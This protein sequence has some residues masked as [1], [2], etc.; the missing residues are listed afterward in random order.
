MTLDMSDAGKAT[1]NGGIVSN[2]AVDAGSNNITTT[3]VITGGSFNVGGTNVIDTSRN[4][5]NMGNVNGAAG[6]FGSLEVDD[7]TINGTEIDL[8]SGSL[9]LDVASAIKLDADGGEV[10][11]LDGGTEI[12]VVSMGNQNMNIESKQA[13]KDII[14]KGIDGSSDLTALTIDMSAAGQLLAVANTPTNPTYSFAGDNNTG[15]TRPTGDTVTIV[16]GGTE[17]VRVDSSGNM[18]VGAEPSGTVKGK[19][20]IDG[21]TG[22]GGIFDALAIKHI[23]TTTTGDGPALKFEGE[24]NSNDWALA[25]LQVSNGGAGYGANVEFKLHPGDS[26]QGSNVAN[27]FGLKRIVSNQLQMILHAGGASTYADEAS[28]TISGVANTSCL[29]SIQSQR[30][31][32]SNSIAYDAALFFCHYGIDS[33]SSVVELADPGGTFAGSDTDGMVC[34]YKGNNSAD[35]IVKNR[36]GYSTGLSIQVIPFLGN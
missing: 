11:F 10:Q 9:T 33:G 27:A 4:L 5:V 12:G 14:F 26:V 18:S 7:I 19:I 16:T 25:K 22:S 23:N 13:D 6:I 28:Y 21:G 8:S 35:V 29:I 31:A 1:F 15:I 36:L 32:G 34:V 20:H 17:R 30:R 3:G 2:G 24:Y